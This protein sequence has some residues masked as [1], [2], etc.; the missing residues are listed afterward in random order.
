[1]HLENR[2]RFHTR[3]ENGQPPRVIIDGTHDASPIF[4]ERDIVIF[5]GLMDR[6]LGELLPHIHVTGRTREEL[7]T[8]LKEGNLSF[9][10]DDDGKF[11]RRG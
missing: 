8:L 2:P 3:V 11:I 4:S 10:F 6:V 5:G 7:A 1:M 9:I